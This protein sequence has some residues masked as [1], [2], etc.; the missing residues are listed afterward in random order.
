MAP[1]LPN[2]SAHHAHRHR[3]QRSEQANSI[4]T[5][6]RLAGHN[7]NSEGIQNEES[8]DH[9]DIFVCGPPRIPWPELWKEHRTSVE[10]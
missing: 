8:V 4:F 6:C 10:M 7:G 2:A 9:P 5:D 1:R 3:P